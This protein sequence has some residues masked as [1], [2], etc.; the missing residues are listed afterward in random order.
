MT[1]PGT[2]YIIGAGP[3]SLDYLTL[4]GRD[5]LQRAE[6]LVYDALVDEGLLG[7][8]P[9]GCDRINV[10][11]RGGQPSPPQSEIT[12]LL[13]KLSLEGRQVVRL[14]SGDPFIFGRTAAE[15]QALHEA[16]C[17][18]EVV[19]G[20]SSALAA[21]L[22]A[23]IPLTDPVWS[24]GFGVFTAHDLDLLD[25]P[26]LARLR[27]LVLLMGSRHLEEIVHRL[28]QNG[29]RGD[30]PVAIIRWGGHLQQQVWEGTLLTI[31]QVTR[32]ETLSPCVMVFGEV[33]RL[34]RYL[35]VSEPTQ[36]S[37][38]K[39]QNSPPHHPLTPLPLTQ[40]T[41]LIT[42]A[43]EQS[44]A[45]ADLLTAQGATV[46]DLPALEMRSPSSWAGLDGAIAA[47]PTFHWLILSSANAVNFFV[48]RL[49]DQGKDLRALSGLKIAVVGRKTAAVLKK[50]GLVPDFIPPD[51][52]ADSLVDHFPEAVAGQR[53]LF[54]RVESG[55]REVL[56]QEFT[57]AGAE[58]VEVAAYESGCPEVPDAGALAA[59]K[60]G[61]VDVITF[62]SSKTVVHTA[63][64]LEQGLGAGWREVL[65]GV[66]I[67][68]IGPK[69][70]DSCHEILGR[71]DIEPAEYTLDGLTEAIAAWASASSG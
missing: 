62:A 49:L 66:A 69:T 32:G 67:A 71:V 28:R 61:R 52:V 43:T 48:D 21:P 42:R 65:K 55:G 5:L 45:F 14:K 6:C 23:G 50:R 38:F 36:N 7:L 51:F 64:L 16:G 26:T 9:R 63:Q 11:K 68:S 39:I 22:L 24:H 60:Q 47:L 57:A 40:K 8:L 41:I 18:V 70:S 59:L 3:G 54:P 33:V 27:T 31:H 15:V 1:E 34:R 58:V 53:L 25:W 46:V 20:V 56:V 4:R 35:A 29:C 17:P 19:P 13:V 30:M 12:Q 2:V 10:G 44:S 37:K